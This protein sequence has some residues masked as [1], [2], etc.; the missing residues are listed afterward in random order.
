MNGTN[1]GDRPPNVEPTGL[2][3]DLAQ[4][5]GRIEGQNQ[6]ILKEQGRASENRKEQYEALEEVRSNLAEM[7]RDVTS[8]TASVAIMKP[9]VDEM[10]GFRA[11]VALGMVFVTAVVTGAINLIWLGVTNLGHIKI[12]LREFLR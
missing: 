11:Q 7:K 9:D 12:W 1:D 4:A 6:L 3:L 8:V 5:L 10:K 2:L